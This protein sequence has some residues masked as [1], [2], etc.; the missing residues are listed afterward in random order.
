MRKT[1][2]IAIVFFL[3]L[4]F[5]GVSGTLMAKESQ[6]P[7]KPINMYMGFP[8]GGTVGIS[9]QVITEML[10]E[11]LGQPIIANYKPGAQQAVAGSLIAKEK[12]DGYNLLWEAESDFSNHILMESNS[13]TF[14]RED[15]ISIGGTAICPYLLVVKSDAPWKTLEDVIAYGKKNPGELSYG[16]AGVGAMNHLGMELFAYK[17][18]IKVNHIPFQGGGPALTALL[19]GHVKIGLATPGRIS[20]LLKAG[21]LRALVVFSSK[22][23]EEFPEVPTFK[24]KGYE[25]ELEL[26]HLL[27]APKGL[28]PPV[29]EKLVQAFKMAL[30]M[31]KYKAILTRAGFDPSYMSPEYIDKRIEKDKQDVITIL[32]GM[33]L[34]KK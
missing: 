19:G 34:Q 32:K 25:A 18:G 13:L 28:E 5:V 16:S 6:F 17:T 22:R 11:A 1:Y 27:L 23:S 15:F 10:K 3:S 12:P 14:K 20:S 33:G 21:T 26:F 4:F 8:P 2:R 29:R 9:G 7:T 30:Q 31:P 24:E